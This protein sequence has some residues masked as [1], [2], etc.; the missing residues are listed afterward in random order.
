VCACDFE[1]TLGLKQS[2]TSYHLKQLVE[3]GLVG[4]QRRGTYSYYRVVP[5]ALDRVGALLAE[6]GAH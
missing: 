4:R 2:L 5:G 3:A 6:A 1:L